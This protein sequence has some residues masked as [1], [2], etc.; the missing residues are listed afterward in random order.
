MANWNPIA[1]GTYFTTYDENSVMG[2]CSRENGSPWIQ[3]LSPND[4][5]GV[6]SVYGGPFFNPMGRL[7]ETYYTNPGLRVHKLSPNSNGTW[8]FSFQD[9]NSGYGA[10]DMANW[11]P[12]NRPGAQPSMVDTY[13][14]GIGRGLRIHSA[15]NNGTS[16]TFRYDDINSGYGVNDMA[17]WKVADINGDGRDD[18]V[19]PFYA[20]PPVGLRIHYAISNSDNSWT[21]GYRDV[22]TGYGNPNMANW[23]VA[24]INGD[25]RVDL[26]EPYFR[27]AGAGLRIHYVTSN[28]NG[29]WT[30][31]YRDVNSGY[32]NANMANWRVGDV[33][34][35]GR[36]DLVEPYYLAPGLRIHYVTSNANGTW[37]FGYR[38]VNPGYGANDMANWKV[39]DINGDRRADLVGPFF[40]GTGTGGLRIHS[41][42]SNVDNSWS[43]QFHD[44]NPGYGANDMA[45]WKVM[46]VDR[47]GLA[48]LVDAYF[49]GQGRGL[50]IHSAIS[51]G[52]GTWMFR[53]S[54]PNS[55]YG[56]ADMTRWKVGGL[57]RGLTQ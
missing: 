45:N 29:T 6:R 4:V 43:F 18:L 32:G 17:N 14:L 27:G 56:A 30:F 3:D 48:D 21:F 47:D 26:V 34:G 8:A 15:I 35:D 36:D 54:D 9:I 16:W 50:R 39:A 41:A 28:S 38:D 42:I 37:S 2:Y 20:G 12:V 33:N 31:G 10:N 52:D 19:D 13:F 40:R 55:G 24:D 23:R 44:I 53:Y 7:L 57:R 5:A 46:D 11:K 25:G 1:G 22:N 51:R 49:L